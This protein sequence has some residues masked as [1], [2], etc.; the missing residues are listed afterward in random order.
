MG[1]GAGKS[2]GV[3]ALGRTGVKSGLGE[4]PDETGRTHVIGVSLCAD[5]GVTLSLHSAALVYD[6]TM[7]LVLLA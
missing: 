7:E 5:A 4:L 3:T 6:D 2:N 1:L